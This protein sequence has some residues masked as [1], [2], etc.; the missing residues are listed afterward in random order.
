[1]RMHWPRLYAF[2]AQV[3]ADRLDLI[4]DTTPGPVGL[5]ARHV[6]AKLRL[7]MVGSFQT[8]LS[9]YT[10]V[11][12][13]SRRLGQGASTPIASRRRG[14]PRP[15]A[16]WAARRRGAMMVAVHVDRP[17]IAVEPA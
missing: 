2:L 10:E 8:L 12:S 4:H 15:G 17:E 6:A 16:A 14:D 11:L 7:P 5:A 3:R 13:G 9:E 1:M